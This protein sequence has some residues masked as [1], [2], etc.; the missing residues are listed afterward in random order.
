MEK[1]KMFY[2]GENREMVLEKCHFCKELNLSDCKSCLLKMP[3]SDENCP[4]YEAID[5]DEVSKR[6]EYLLE[7]I[8][9]PI[10]GD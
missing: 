1:H 9:N 3:Q 4:A 7:V 6:V 2:V 5:H 10:K 8:G